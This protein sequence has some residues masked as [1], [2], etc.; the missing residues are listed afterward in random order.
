MKKTL[1]ILLV[2][3]VAL[4]S[5][6]AADLTLTNTV[7]D[8]ET[9]ITIK[10]GKENSS[11]TEI[12]EETNDELTIDSLSSGEVYFEI[13]VTGNSSTNKNVSVGFSSTDFEL[14]G[15]GSNLAVGNTSVPTSISKESLTTSENFD[16]TTFDDTA[17]EFKTTL[18]KYTKVVDESVG[19][20]KV[21]WANDD[22][23]NPLVAGVYKS[24]ITI[25]IGS[26]A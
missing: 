11:I 18:K 17:K 9:Q 3:L 19:K 21:T 15:E 16:G 5:V 4:T 7:P 6:F 2:A 20:I 22:E 26:E 10:Y 14:T 1:A 23:N 12:L 24:T 25:T 13:F 8:A